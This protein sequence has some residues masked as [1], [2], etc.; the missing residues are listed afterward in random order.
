VLTTKIIP[1]AV[2]LTAGSFALYS[3]AA[4]LQ[5]CTTHPDIFRCDNPRSP[6]A[7]VPHDWPEPTPGQAPTGFVP[8]AVST[9]ATTSLGWSGYGL[10]SIK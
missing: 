7:D 2:I 10:A 5:Y 6:L 1:G 3:A 4:D 8:G 9:S